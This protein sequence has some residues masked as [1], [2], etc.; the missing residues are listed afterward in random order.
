MSFNFA[1]GVVPDATPADLAAARPLSADTV[2][3]DEV[4]PGTIALAQIGSHVVVLDPAMI[5]LDEILGDWADRTDRAAY[6][7]IFSGVSDTYVLQ[8][9]GPVA[10]LRV[11]SQGELVED[12]GDA[13]AAEAEAD[14]VGAEFEEDRHIALVE[15]LLGHDMAA[16]FDARFSLLD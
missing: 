9:F 7:V 14:A 13:L 4:S 16:V 15:K 1:L 11:L 6:G 8:A 3:F 12:E 10:R 2:A 5:E